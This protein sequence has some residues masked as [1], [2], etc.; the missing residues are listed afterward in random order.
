LT[1]SEKRNPQARRMPA[2]LR[3]MVREAMNRRAI[4]LSEKTGKEEGMTT[5]QDVRTLLIAK[6]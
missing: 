6:K 5:V 3:G 4:E 2:L 1:V